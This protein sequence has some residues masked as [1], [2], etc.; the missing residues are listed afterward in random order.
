MGGKSASYS[1]CERARTG[2]QS[3]GGHPEA[4]HQ[5]GAAGHA[6]VESGMD[7]DG[8]TGG[9]GERALERI[10]S[11]PSGSEW[12][13]VVLPG[14]APRTGLPVG[15]SHGGSR[16]RGNYRAV[17]RGM[18][19]HRPRRARRARHRCPP[20]RRVFFRIVLRSRRVGRRQRT[21]GDG[22]ER[23]AGLCALDSNARS[24]TDTVDLQRKR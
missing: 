8:R 14:D 5:P 11:G 10:V 21:I 22:Y 24:A 1:G 4:L 20:E 16:P 18:A 9:S 23:G 12:T 17:R 2:R 15:A 3:D 19:K 13:G 7:W 6:G